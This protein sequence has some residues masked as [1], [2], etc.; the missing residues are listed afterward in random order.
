MADN[1]DS[2][3]LDDLKEDL[4]LL[5]IGREFPTR[6][7]PID[8][9]AIDRDGELYIIETKLFKNPDKRRVVAQM[10]DYGAALWQ[11]YSDPDDFVGDIDA[12][13]M[14][15]K[16]SGLTAQL[17]TLYEMEE[18]HVPA[19]T[20]AIKR[21]LISG[22]MRFIVLM[23]RLSERLRN[24]ILFINQKSRFNIYAVEMEFYR[25][26]GMEIVIPRLHGAEVRKD[27]G[28]DKPKD[29]K[30]VWDESRF[31]AVTKKN[32]SDVSETLAAV[33][34]LFAFSSNTASDI[35]L[36]NVDFQGRNC[37]AHIFFRRLSSKP[38]Y[39]IRTDG[40][41]ELNLAWLEKGTGTAL[42]ERFESALRAANFR[43]FA[44]HDSDGRIGLPPDMWVRHEEAFEQVVRNVFTVG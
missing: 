5:V 6:S 38:A 11:G 24:L 40:V 37:R 33:E 8:V 23:D 29:E 21:N 31:L 43:D 36:R 35:K 20:E 19:V 30:Y 7:G 28:I 14:Q 4:R 18:E 15:S 17:R 10:L 12:T 22:S 26:E 44:A 2:L 9:L 32:L 1:P 25:H 34:R 39:S 13:L 42:R 16:G 27:V 3:P 41:L